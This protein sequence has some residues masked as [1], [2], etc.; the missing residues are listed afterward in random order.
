MFQW[1]DNSIAYFT[2]YSEFPTKPCAFYQTWENPS[3]GL[4]TSLCWE[5][6]KLQVL[7]EMKQLLKSHC[8]KKIT[9]RDSKK[10]KLLKLLTF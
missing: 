8:A 1:S 7:C 2:N 4:K 5:K 6:I 10:K 3:H 9:D